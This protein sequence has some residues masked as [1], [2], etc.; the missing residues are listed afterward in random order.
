MARAYD[1]ISLLDGRARRIR[2]ESIAPREFLADIR[3]A[4]FTAIKERLHR[5]VDDGDLTAPAECTDA[6]AHYYA[7]MVQ[8]LSVQARDGATR[9]DLEAVINCAMAA[10]DP[11]T[12]TS[13][14]TAG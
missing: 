9:E 8:G 13:S 5:A 12:R 2:R 4:Q 6:L 7:T 3:R 14:H 10:W 1:R 11:I